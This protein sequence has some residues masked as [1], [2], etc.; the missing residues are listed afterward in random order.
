MVD[1]DLPP[2]RNLYETVIELVGRSRAGDTGARDQMLARI[3]DFLSLVARRELEQEL[4]LKVGVSDIVQC[5]LLRVCDNVESFAG[6]S[7]PQFLAWLK[8]IVVNEIRRERRRQTAAKR[9]VRN[10]VA[11]SSALETSPAAIRNLTRRPSPHSEVVNDERLEILRDILAALP[12]EHATI[13]VL[14]NL[15][16][17]SF[18]EIG[19]RLGRSENAATKLWHRAMERFQVELKKRGIDPVET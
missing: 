13:I 19:E 8:T 3:H 10:E 14:R 15:E 2:D 9:D 16:S 12:D 7:K 4:K 5:S 17:R 11:F 1:S 6:K 18:A